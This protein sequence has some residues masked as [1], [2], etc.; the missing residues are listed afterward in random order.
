[1][2]T[3]RTTGETS[4]THEVRDADG[5]PGPAMPGVRAR[6]RTWRRGRPFWGG[7]LVLLSGVELFFSGQLD[8]G[9]L[10]V[11][12]G[13]AGMQA[14]IIPVVLV[15]LGVLLWTMPVH[16]VFYGVIAMVLAVYSIVGVNLGGFLVGML[17][18]VVGG[19]VAVSW[20]PRRP[21]VPDD[22]PA[23]GVAVA[24]AADASAA[25]APADDT[26]E[27]P[28]APAREPVL[29]GTPRH[30]SAEPSGVDALFPAVR[31]STDG[32]DGAG[33]TDET[34][35]ADG[36][37]VSLPA[38]VRPY[39]AASRRTNAWG[40]VAVVAGLATGLGGAGAPAALHAGSLHAEGP[41]CTLLGPLCPSATDGSADDATGTA[42][43]E[44]TADPTDE[45]TEGP[46][47]DPAPDAPSS[48][49]TAAPETGQDDPATADEA[50][51]PGTVDPSS[52]TPTSAPTAEATPSP[53]AA[54]TAEA[55]PAPE[56][57]QTDAMPQPQLGEGSLT[58]DALRLT[59]SFY[60]GN[61]TLTRP[62]GSTV[63]VMTF[64]AKKVEVPGFSLDA[65][66][67]QGHGV[68]T[69][70]STMSIETDVVLYCTRLAGRL[71]GIPVSYT[72]DSPPPSVI[73]LPSLTDPE[74]ALVSNTGGTLTLADFHQA[75][76]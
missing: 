66:D 22:V 2:S 52:S 4:G 5:T 42:T 69:T 51:D 62:D 31:G 6:F 53:T 73:P 60:A 1:M 44:P 56:L 65:V 58:G 35:E 7:L 47:E 28:A 50:Q 75:L 12:V 36:T 67:A 38:T 20:L 70:A 72:P 25:P 33:R 16:R 41:L 24:P 30:R 39:T 14:T 34:A 40:A 19:V 21:A 32:D 10:H 43:D 76:R 17:L 8:L 55:T 63:E 9:N 23:D 29:E 3:E 64:T 37:A 45:P 74:I 71:L 59:S 68:L 57:E 27:L 18:G 54:P 61:T 11:Q 15:L 26:A 46:A 13:V 49:A 48:G